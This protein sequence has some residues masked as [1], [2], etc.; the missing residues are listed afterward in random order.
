MINPDIFSLFSKE[1]DDSQSAYIDFTQS[2]FYYLYQYQKIL[3]TLDDTK[4][5]LKYLQKLKKEVDIK[6]IRKA[7]E[8]ILFEKSWESISNINIEE[9]EHQEA[10]SENNSLEFRFYIN[11]SIK[12]YLELEEYEKCAFLQKILDFLKKIEFSLEN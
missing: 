1:T 4:K 7:G 8:F 2:P 12:H 3:S 6:E 5:F 10:L 11:L 9:K